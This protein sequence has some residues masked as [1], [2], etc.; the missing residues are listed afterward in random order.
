MPCGSAL[1]GIF[2]H[3]RLRH[4]MCRVEALCNAHHLLMHLHANVSQRDPVVGADMA[5]EA[6]HFV[7]FLQEQV[8][9][10]HHMIA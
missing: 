6:H 10:P 3:E 2:S 4:R 1:S 5:L 7:Q 9:V 8:G